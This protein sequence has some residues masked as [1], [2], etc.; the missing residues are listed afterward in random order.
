ME[1]ERLSDISGT[2]TKK[3]MEAKIEELDTN[4]KIISIRNWYRNINDF[5]KVTSL[6]LI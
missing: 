1:D 3:Y 4:S 6:Q 2:K 5:K